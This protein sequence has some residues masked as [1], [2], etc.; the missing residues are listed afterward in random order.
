MRYAIIYYGSWIGFRDGK[1]T[2]FDWTRQALRFATAAAA[3]RFA[4]EHRLD[5]GCYMV[6]EI[7]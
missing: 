5:S 6:A 2:M 4:V 1:V 7:T 3:E